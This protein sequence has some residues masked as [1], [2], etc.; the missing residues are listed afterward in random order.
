MGGV[1]VVGGCVGV[2]VGAGAGAG[3]DGDAVVGGAVGGAAGGAGGGTV[4]GVEASTV[5]GVVMP[6]VGSGAEIGPTPALWVVPPHAASD[7]R[8]P[9]ATSA[10][11]AV[12]RRVVVAE[13]DA[14][15]MDPA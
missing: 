15:L 10:D 3:G 6:I 1:V 7:V 11:R 4:S 13:L 8:A 14:V 12:R 2:G 5:S 9:T